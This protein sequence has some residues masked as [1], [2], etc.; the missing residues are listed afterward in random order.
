MEQ[1]E[2]LCHFISDHLDLTKYKIDNDYGDI[3]VYSINRGVLIFSLINAENAIMELCYDTKPRFDR[4]ERH[5]IGSNYD[6]S[7]R[8]D[9]ANPNSLDKIKEGLLKTIEIYEAWDQQKSSTKS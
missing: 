7:V 3:D 1:K 2:L 4:D 8:L 5:Y 9:I 6:V